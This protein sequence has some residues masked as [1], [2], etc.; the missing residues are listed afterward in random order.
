MLDPC[1]TSSYISE[2]AAGELE[3]HRQSLHLTIAGTGGTEIQKHS[4]RVELSVTS[5]DGSFSAPLQAH[6]LDNIASDTPAFQWSELKEKWPHLCQIPFDNVAKCRYIDVMIGSDHPLFHLVLNEVH[7]GLPNDPIARLTTLGWICFG[8]TLVEEFRRQSQSHFTRTYRSSQINPQPPPD[9]ILRKFW[10]LEA[11][12]IK[13]TADKPVMTID[14]RAATTTVAESLKFINGRYE[15]GIPWKAG[16]LK[17]TNNYQAALLRLQSQEKFLRKKN[18][19]IVEAYSKVFDDY[20]KK[21]YIQRVPK[22]RSSG[23]CH[24]FPSSS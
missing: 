1:S 15:V 22:S 24:I 18:P 13:E 9:D 6:V 3:L 10:E 2:H 16:E 8:P 17:L 11:L 4:R 20:E 7:G 23:S 21:A 12:G 19:D 5:L 14:E